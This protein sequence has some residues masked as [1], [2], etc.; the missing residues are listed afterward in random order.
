MFPKPKRIKDRGL[1][2]EIKKLRCIA[3]GKY[4]VDPAHIRSRGAGGHDLVGWVI[5]LCRPCHSLSHH[6]GWVRF[7][8]KNF[9]VKMTLE[10]LG[11][12]I[13]NGKLR[14]KE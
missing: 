6:I 12:I 8:E 9:N 5:P 11:W 1:L 13:E 3:C 4:G 10:E 14:R 2:D 7:L